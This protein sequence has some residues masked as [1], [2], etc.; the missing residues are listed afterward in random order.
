MTP[1]STVN[2]MPSEAYRTSHL[3]ALV[4]QIRPKRHL[5]SDTRVAF[6]SGTGLTGSILTAMQDITT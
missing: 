6:S 1:P 3:P 5:K 2:R 4:A